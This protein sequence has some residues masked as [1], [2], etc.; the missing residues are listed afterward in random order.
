MDRITDKVYLGNLISARDEE[1]LIKIIS[2]EFFHVMGNMHHNIKVN[3]L[4]IKFS[5]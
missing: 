4:N 2:Q 5:I 1:N 3:Q